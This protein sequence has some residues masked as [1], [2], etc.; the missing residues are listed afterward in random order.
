M[1]QKVCRVS[2]E[3]PKGQKM[4]ILRKIKENILQ[5]IFPRRCPVCDD[6]VRPY[7]EKICLKCLKKVK[8]LTPPWCMKCGKKLYQEGEYC[9]DCRKIQHKYIRG[10]ALYEYDSVATSI[11]RMKYGDRQEYADFFGEE[12]A[13]YLGSFIRDCTPDAL[14]PIPLHR[15]RQ[16]K[17]GYNQAQLLAE[18]LGRCMGVPVRSDLLC[19]VKNTAP[20]KRQNPVERQNN[21]KKAFNIAQNDVKLDTI[22]IIDDIYTTGCTID[23]A[24]EVL[25]QHGV[26]RVFYVT[27]ACGSGV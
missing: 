7:G 19:R 21:L 8:L 3:G 16:N 18:A 5:L 27:L 17:R 26:K 22:I 25:M 2:G 13:C 12:M 14:I 23:E 10:R 4:H 15:K 24:T 6:I 9:A 11:Y 20:L 1:C